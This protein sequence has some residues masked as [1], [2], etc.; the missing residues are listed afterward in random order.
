MFQINGIIWRIKFVNPYHPM[1][2]RDNGE[3]SVGCCNNF[4]KTIYLNW[5]LS[6]EFLK[7]VLTHEISHA[8]LFSYNVVLPLYIEEEVADLIATYGY[9]ITYLSNKIY[10][11]IEK[12][13]YQFI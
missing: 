12:D 4:D 3:Y 1:L 9:E 13:Q 7:K 11:D 10:K 2:Q 5:N 8:A 6:G